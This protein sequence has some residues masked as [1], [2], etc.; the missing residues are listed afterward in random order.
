V[1]VCVLVA[2]STGQ[3][4]T[5]WFGKK[6]KAQKDKTGGAAPD[7]EEEAY[8]ASLMELARVGSV[9][10]FWYPKHHGHN[11]CAH[12]KPQECVSVAE[13][14]QVAGAGFILLFV[15]WLC[16]AAMGELDSGRLHHCQAEEGDARMMSWRVSHTEAWD[17]D[18]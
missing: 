6:K 12:S 8:Q 2:H 3:D 1:I 7:K 17:A 11:T 9:E 15:S 4:W 10:Q 14:C 5:L 18:Y 13:A 16:G